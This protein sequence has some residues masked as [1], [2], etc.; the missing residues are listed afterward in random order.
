MEW[1][2]HQNAYFNH[3]HQCL[4][5]TV[6]RPQRGRSHWGWWA[7]RRQGCRS[8]GSESGVACTLRR[9]AAAPVGRWQRRGAGPERAPR[10]PRRGATPSDG[11]LLGPPGR[12][13][14]PLAMPLREGE[15][16]KKTK[17]MNKKVLE[18]Y[19]IGSF[20]W[21]QTKPSLGVKSQYKHILHRERFY[22]QKGIVT[23]M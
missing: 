20:Y 16:R 13:Q 1:P 2:R 15:A 19:C 22:I 14:S 5:L 10:S 6:S 8:G 7:A 12:R 23:P 11:T 9:P 21:T 3:R 17:D 18:W 4:V